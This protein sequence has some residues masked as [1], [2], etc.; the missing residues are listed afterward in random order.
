MPLLIGSVGR[1][2]SDDRALCTYMANGMMLA[3]YS[4]T[5]AHFLEGH[6]WGERHCCQAKTALLIFNGNGFSTLIPHRISA[7]ANFQCWPI[8]HIVRSKGG[9]LSFLISYS[10]N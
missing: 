10:R 9:S 3:F 6:K 7:T 8:E 4:G 2:K 5:N 1:K